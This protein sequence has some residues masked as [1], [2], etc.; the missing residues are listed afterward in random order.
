MSQ[1]L[2]TKDDVSR[3]LEMP[4]DSVR[5]DTADRVCRAYIT[6]T[7][8]ESQRAIAEEVFRLLVADQSSIVRQCVAENLQNSAE[9][10]HDVAVKL[11]TDIEDSVALPMLRS[12]QVLSED[13][14]LCIVKSMEMN[15]MSA[16]A[17]R[18]HISERVCEE[19]VEHGDQGVVVRLIRN[20][21][22]DISE[23]S[24]ESA[25]AR[26]R[27][28]D[29]FHSAV[30]SRDRLPV[31][32]RSKILSALTDQVFMTLAKQDN[33]SPSIVADI[34]I[35]THDKLVME[36]SDKT[37]QKS[38]EE[39]VKSLDA[40]GMLTQRILMRALCQ[41]DALF[42][43]LAM[44]QMAD[45]PLNNTRR[46]LY[47][48]GGQGFKALYRHAGLNA[49]HLDFFQLAFE[50]CL[51]LIESGEDAEQTEFRRKLIE[52]LLTEGFDVVDRLEGSDVEYLLGKL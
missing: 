46:L 35:Q 42:F 51:E 15:R 2:L 33:I 50:M 26:Y 29:S 47:D 8:S 23:T 27:D 28:N 49:A 48:L 31:A 22:A 7:L 5:A 21:G 34:V 11:A 41:G 45:L 43:E 18:P 17:E 9:V 25:Y 30:V 14:L 10:P 3:L 13:D 37:T 52:R 20:E 44:S 4:T 40:R 32:V 12:S 38:V 36:L 16:I 24:F 39:L 1:S 19:L 6:E